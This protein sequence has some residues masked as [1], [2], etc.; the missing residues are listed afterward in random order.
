MS[1]EFS[2]EGYGE[3]LR[4]A[5]DA[6]YGV[7]PMRDAV[8]APDRRVLMLRHDVDFSLA[9]ALKMA[10]AE[11]AMGVR[12]TYFI[13]LYNDYY[14][15]LAPGGRRLVEQVAAMGHEIGLH[16]DSSIYP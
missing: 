10:A 8:Q 5:L 14:N 7:M 4:S 16:W 2:P 12:S 9:Y 15:P 6:G 3:L 11:Q 13:L 1:I